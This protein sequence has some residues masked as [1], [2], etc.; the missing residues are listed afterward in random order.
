MA[1]AIVQLSLMQNQLIPSFL[2]YFVSPVKTK[3]SGATELF[4]PDGQPSG[5]NR[6]PCRAVPVTVFLTFGS[7]E[8]NSFTFFFGLS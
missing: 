7:Q 6:I 3:P 1:S 8:Y 5:E 2:D 4:L